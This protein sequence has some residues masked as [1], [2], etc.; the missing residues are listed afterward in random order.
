MTATTTLTYDTV[1]DMA[2]TVVGER[3]DYI[4]DE[5][6]ETGGCYNVKDG[7][8][9][10][11]V[12]HILTRLGLPIEFF[13]DERHEF[14]LQGAA[15]S[16]LGDAVDDGYFAFPSDHDSRR[17]HT[18]LAEMQS[19]QDARHPWGESLAWGIARVSY[20]HQNDEG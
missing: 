15:T 12:G 13:T 5:Q 20:Y 9:S 19:H 1:L 18:L 8:A 6:D 3:P 7:R 2:R 10:C 4:Y 17:I 11:V 14:R 16:T